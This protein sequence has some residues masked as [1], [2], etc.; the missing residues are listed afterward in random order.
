MGVHWKIQFLVGGRKNNILGGIVSKR[1]T[2]IVCRFKRR[3]DEKEGMVILRVSWYP[4]H[5][6]DHF[7]LVSIKMYWTDT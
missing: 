4:M 6:M 1:G 2:W 7:T 3:L 5:T